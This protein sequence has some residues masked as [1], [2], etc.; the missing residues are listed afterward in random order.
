[1]AE[2]VAVIVRPGIEE[3][4]RMADSPKN[5]G[6]VLLSNLPAGRGES[7]FA[8][9]II[10]VSSIIF[11]VLAPFAKLPVAPLPTF[12]P[13]YQSALVINDFITVV[14]LLSQRQ[15]GH[16]NAMS[17]LAGGY[18]FTA[19][20]SI[21]HALTFPGLF[22][23]TGLLGAGPQTTAW[24]YM[25]WHGGFP[26]FVIGYAICG[27]SVPISQPKYPAILI[28]V[29]FVLGAACSVTLVSTWGQHVL[30]TIM[31]GDQHTANMNFVVWSVW[32]LNFLPLRSLRAAGRIRN[33]ICG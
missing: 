9:T 1:M 18:L 11:L 29:A 23:S 25:F 32:L 26:L 20:I 19:L 33:W 22:S 31:Q 2:L 4:S 8:T 6:V 16:A 24:L 5:E 3:K 21:V 28:M 12:I 30:P 13:I 10:A 27:R 17:F 7:R 14:F 15:F